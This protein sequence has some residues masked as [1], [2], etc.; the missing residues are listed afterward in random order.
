MSTYDVFARFYDLD[1]AGYVADLPFWVNLARRASGPV[2]EPACGTGRVLL[3]LARAGF[4]VVGVDVSAAM[5]DVARDKLAAAGL[6]ERVELIQADLLELDLGRRFALAL[7]ALNSFGHFAEPGAPE[8]ALA[9]VRAHLAPAGLLA[10]DLPNPVPG[11]FGETS[12]VVLHE[13]TRDGPRPGWKTLKLRS[14]ELDPVAQRV[15]VSCVYDEVSPDGEVRRTLASFSL[16]YFYLHEICL[17]CD[18]AGLVV[19]DVF[20]SY[21]LDPLTPESERMIVIA[22]NVTRKA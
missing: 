22:K 3:P 20:G 18:Q 1:T 4:E 21:D 13:Y 2:L 9:A 10:L 17:L 8:R 11:A 5:L 15:D 19:E 6:R 12:S 14:Q 16:R 7:I